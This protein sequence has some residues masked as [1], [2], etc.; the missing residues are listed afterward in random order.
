MFFPLINNLECQAFR[1]CSSFLW[2][3]ANPSRWALFTLVWAGSN[4][5]RWMLISTSKP[6]VIILVFLFSV[7][8]T[9][10]C[11]LGIYISRAIYILIFPPLCL[12]LHA[13]EY[14]FSVV[15]YIYI[16]FL[17]YNKLQLDKMKNKWKIF[18]KEITKKETRKYSTSIYLTALSNR[19]VRKV[20]RGWTPEGKN[21][22][23]YLKLKKKKKKQYQN[24]GTE[25]L[26]VVIMYLIEAFKMRLLSMAESFES[27]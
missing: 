17:Q 4:T 13:R 20:G 3:I 15:K 27:S 5:K 14:Q 21:E 1:A 19:T 23:I 16:F 6:F 8:N 10:W 22:Y 25:N 2:K 7:L 18:Y 9:V 26:F 12:H 24:N 11:S